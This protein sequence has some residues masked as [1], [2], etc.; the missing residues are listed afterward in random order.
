[1]LTPLLYYSLFNTLA[2]LILSLKH[3]YSLRQQ[4]PIISCFMRRR[5]FLILRQRFHRRKALSL[6]PHHSSSSSSSV[7]MEEPAFFCN[8]NDEMEDIHQDKPGGYHPVRLGDVLPREPASTSTTHRYRILQKLGH[9]AFST[10]WLAKDV[11][12]RL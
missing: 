8:G 1:M 4:P 9:G 7:R 3:L 12:N 11:T 6:S 2:L 10:V 5:Y